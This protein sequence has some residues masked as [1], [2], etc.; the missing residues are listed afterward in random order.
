MQSANYKMEN[1][2]AKMRNNLH[3]CKKVVLKGFLR[4]SVI[5]C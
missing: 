1:K 3:C 2:I 4:R 5:A